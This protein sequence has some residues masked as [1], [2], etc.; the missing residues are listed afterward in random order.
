[1]AIGL[2]EQHHEHQQHTLFPSQLYN[3]LYN[4]SKDIYT[5]GGPSNLGQCDLILGCISPRLDT[6]ASNITWSMHSNGYFNMQNF[7]RV[8]VSNI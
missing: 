1:M 4:N 7:L 6:T 3:S 5:V 8:H 2:K